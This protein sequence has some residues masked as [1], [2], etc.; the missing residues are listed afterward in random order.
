MTH[1]QKFVIFDVLAVGTISCVNSSRAVILCCCSIQPSGNSIVSVID[2]FSS[3]ID[4]T[5]I[6]DIFVQIAWR[7]CPRRSYKGRLGFIMA[8][9]HSFI[10]SYSFNKS[11]QN[12]HLNIKRVVKSVAVFV[13]NTYNEIHHH[14]H[15]RVKGEGRWVTT[16]PWPRRIYGM[17]PA[18]PMKLPYYIWLIL[19]ISCLLWRLWSEVARTWWN[20]V[21]NV[22][23]VYGVCISARSDRSEALRLKSPVLCVI[24]LSKRKPV[25]AELTFKST[26]ISR[27][28]WFWWW[29]LWLIMPTI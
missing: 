27:I 16:A 26:E 28:M 6:S 29:Q 18:V 25:R 15:D 1:F 7:T 3:P 10:Y 13:K 24:F 4:M 5:F 2:A 14:H 8:F 17:P 23:C 19:G 21:S 20:R 22:S 9:I 11:S 12:E